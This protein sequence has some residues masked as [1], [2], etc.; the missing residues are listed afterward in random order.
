MLGAM[1]AVQAI[2]TVWRAALDADGWP[3]VP[4]VIGSPDTDVINRCFVAALSPV[5]DSPGVRSEWLRRDLAFDEGRHF[6]RVAAEAFDGKG[7]D[8]ATLHTGALT[9]RWFDLLRQALAT[10]P[11]LRGKAQEARIDGEQLT[12]AGWTADGSSTTW[13]AQVL[14]VES[15]RQQPQ[16][17]A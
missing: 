7:S 5:D 12:F 2:L 11:F 1:G 16:P 4:V 14:V 10:D 6:V 13:T 3:D 17:D 9:G 8:E 15:V